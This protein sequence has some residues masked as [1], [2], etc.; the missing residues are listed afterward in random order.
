MEWQP[1]ETAPVNEAV[2]VRVGMGMAFAARLVPDAAMTDEEASCDQW[3][4]EHEGEH[5]P[6]WSGGCCWASNEDENTSLQPTHW[7]PLPP[8]PQKGETH[9]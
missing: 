9:D 4:A 3:Q 1:I 2:L 7:M 5:P 8:P 6:C